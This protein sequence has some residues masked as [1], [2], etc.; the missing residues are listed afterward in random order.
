MILL[1]FSSWMR[2]SSGVFVSL[3]SNWIG[4]YSFIPNGFEYW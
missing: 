3:M 2:D 4:D 1:M